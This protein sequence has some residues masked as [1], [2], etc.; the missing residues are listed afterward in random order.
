MQKVSKELLKMYKNNKAKILFT[1]I[2]SKFPVLLRL[3]YGFTFKNINNS[4]VQS[5]LLNF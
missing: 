4:S 3:T 1:N 2:L 5:K